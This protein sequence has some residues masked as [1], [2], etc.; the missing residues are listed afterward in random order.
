MKLYEATKNWPS[1]EQFDSKET[2]VKKF[3]F[4]KEDAVVES[5]LYAYPDYLTRTV[6]CCSVQSGCV[7]SKKFIDTICRRTLQK[8]NVNH[9]KMMTSA[10]IKYQQPRKQRLT[11]G[12]SRGNCPTCGRITWGSPYENEYCDIFCEP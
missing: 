5:V 4:T 2:S 12:K 8:G 11:T 6:I 1:I 3:V 9:R 7:L 10:G